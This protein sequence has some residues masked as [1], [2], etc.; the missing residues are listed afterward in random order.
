MGPREGTVEKVGW[1][2][3]E[4]SREGDDEEDGNELTDGT[5]EGFA[6]G[7]G[8]SMEMLVG[9]GRT[10]V[11]GSADADGAAET[12]DGSCDS[13][14][15]KD[16]DGAIVEMLGSWDADGSTET[17]LGCCDQEGAAEMLGSSDWEGSADSELGSSEID[18]ICVGAPVETKSPH[19]A[20]S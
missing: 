19:D 5:V 4:G 10:D 7:I 20:T 2:D 15:R 12:L 18:G 1:I 9:L 13:V 8:V 14:G 11:L 17:V 16:S 6:V 3:T